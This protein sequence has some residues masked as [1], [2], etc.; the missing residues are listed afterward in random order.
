MKYLAIL[1]FV[2]LITVN[3][4]LL[5]AEANDIIINTDNGKN[6]KSTP[7]WA[8][9]IS[10]H[11]DLKYPAD[12]KNFDY[13]NPNAPKF[14]M[15][16]RAT[17]AD[18]YDSFNSFIPKGNA[19]SGIGLIYESLMVGAGDEAFSQY[20]LLAQFVKMPADRSWVAYRLHE[21]AKWHDGVK[22]TPEDVIWSF[23]ILMEKGSP[24]YRYYYADIVNVEKIGER[25]VKFTFKSGDNRELPLIIGQ[26]SI[27]PKH[28]WQDRDFSKTTLKPPLG[29]G[30][31]KINK[32][33][34]NRYVTYQRV[35]DYWGANIPVNKGKYNFDKIRYDYYSDTTIA[36]EA[37]KAGEY[38]FRIENSAK[39]WAAGYDSPAV[40]A[41]DL[42]KQEFADNTA[43]GMQGFILNQR[44]D[45]FKNP[46]VRKA[47]AAAFDF[48]WSNKAYFYGQYRRSRSYFNASELE[49]KG[50]PGNRELA[51]LEKFR[52][53]LPKEVFTHEY[54]PPNTGAGRSLR[55]NLLW[56]VDLLA[57]A[58][59]VI[60][61]DN[62]KLRN[63]ETG[64]YFTM[65]FMVSSPAMQRVALPM[66]KNLKRLGIDANVVMVDSSQYT[67]RFRK[68]DYDTMVM[69]YGQS[70]SP[71][72]E[73]RSFWGSQA[74][75]D[76]SSYNIAGMKNKVVDSLIESLITAKSRQD[77]IS[78]T[79]ALDRVLQWLYIAI[80]QYYSP[81]NRVAYW[82]RFAIPKIKPTSGISFSTW[83]IDPALDQN[84][85]LQRGNNKKK[86]TIEK[87]D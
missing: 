67:E 84:L 31:Y 55:D 71:G 87:D 61:S 47:L 34:A 11:G 29:S 60:D 25:D 58:G 72:N 48:E 38:D 73:Q 76:P 78:Y 37:L 33:E 26:L 59:W 44:R 53:D 4:P 46:L 74:A 81:N 56:A 3:N 50:L 40:N 75:D 42:I 22:I 79:R 62:L 23:N 86:S 64:Q 10:M 8:H 39:N 17:I 65:E 43:H 63:L 45:K 18:G 82:N 69:N 57:D 2:A 80:P 83:W 54:N 5:A 70:M 16:K 66:V 13:V 36:L 52:K 15:V 27:L 77:L 30:A 51:I 32:F 14:G 28:Y 7:K 41:G 20:G 24:I 35:E 1:A 85:D 49:A 6:I 12:F 9:G 21:D 19:A 68:R